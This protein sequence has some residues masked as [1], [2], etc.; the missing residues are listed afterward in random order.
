[1]P[2]QVFGTCGGEVGAVFGTCLQACH[3]AAGRQT[4]CVDVAL[5]MGTHDDAA[6]AVFPSATQ[7]GVLL[8]GCHLC[9]Y[10]RRGPPQRGVPRRVGA[11]AAQVLFV[12]E[13]TGHVLV[14]AGKGADAHIAR[15]G[16]V[17][18]LRGGLL[19]ARHQPVDG[20]CGLLADGEAHGFAID[21]AHACY[22]VFRLPAG[23]LAAWR[24]TH[25]L[26]PYPLLEVIDKEHT[27]GVG[28][29]RQVD[30]CVGHLIV[31]NVRYGVQV[32]GR[33]VYAHRAHS[34]S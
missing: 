20:R 10:Q 8:L 17:D 16:P 27:A 21:L 11:V 24:G 7:D 30:A 26:P 22:A 29:C 13:G 12:V 23:T 28:R 25:R 34:K 14:H 18:G 4:G 15:F 2:Q 31:V 3:T 19:S 1:M 5:P 32:L 6:L 33:K 9:Q